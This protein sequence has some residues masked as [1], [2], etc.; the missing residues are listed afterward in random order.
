MNSEASNERNSM[1]LS[2]LKTP[3]FK[4]NTFDFGGIDNRDAQSSNNGLDQLTSSSEDDSEM[5]AEG[6][7]DD[8]VSSIASLAD[9]RNRNTRGR[10]QGMR[11]NHGGI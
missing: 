8:D 6:K 7:N 1:P 3:G 2:G 4:G 5:Q 11:I 10:R 9:Y